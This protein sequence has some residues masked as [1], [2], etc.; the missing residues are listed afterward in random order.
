MSDLFAYIVT[1]VIF[2]LISYIVFII[3]L[4]I[5]NPEF[6]NSDGSINWLTPLWVVVLLNIFI[7]ISVGLM[8]EFIT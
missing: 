7:V 6:Y 2:I 5:F 3:I 8:V 4:L 1:F